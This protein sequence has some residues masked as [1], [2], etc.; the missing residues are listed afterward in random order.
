MT[1]ELRNPKASG[2]FQ[3]KS[4][5]QNH[6]PV[7]FSTCLTSYKNALIFG[8]VRNANGNPF[9]PETIKT[10]LKAISVLEGI[11]PLQN[12]N[13]RDRDF[14][15]ALIK[16]LD[17]Y[18]RS[19]ASVWLY[20][21]KAAISFAFDQ[22]CLL[23]PVL[24]LK[25]TVPE[26][27]VYVLTAEEISFV[28][29][30]YHQIKAGL[31]AFNQRAI[32]DYWVVGLLTVARARDMYLWTSA[33]FNGSELRYTQA[34]GK[35]R[36]KPNFIVLPIASELLK[37]IFSDNIQKYGRLLPPVKPSSFLIQTLAKKIDIFNFSINFEHKGKPVTLPR[38]KML[39]V[40]MMRRSGISDMANK[41]IADV[42]IKAAS[43]H[44][45]NSSVFK[46]YKTARPLEMKKAMEDYNKTI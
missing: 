42:F 31:T 13:V 4:E 30:N 46:R 8:D 5:V 15:T 41:G 43:G 10:R 11:K 17:G 32:L 19:S 37:S 12:K 34:K 44:T 28:V 20:Y 9:S 39:S 2:F 26:K 27:P 21:S 22:K 25:V 36:A 23:A 40:H 14:S 3:E 7:T 16:S 38:Y 45:E 24:R 1:S 18:E 35:N 29:N 6:I 33:N